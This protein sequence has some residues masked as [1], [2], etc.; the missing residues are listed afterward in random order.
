MIEGVNIIDL[1][2]IGNENGKV[3]HMIRNDTK[4]FTKFGEIYF[5]TVLHDKVKG[6]HRHKKLT[7]NFAAVFGKIKLVVYDTR[8][9]SKT[10]GKIEQFFLSQEN[11]KLITVPPLVWSG[12]KGISKETSIVAICT[13]LPYN[14]SE[15]ERKSPF[16][17]TIEYD[18]E[19]NEK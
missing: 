8:S 11:Y 15:I 9:D 13:N 19:K 4:N 14:E 1:K 10:K 12:I 2:Q 3:M 5:S 17:K 18:W 7:S 16:D 6:W